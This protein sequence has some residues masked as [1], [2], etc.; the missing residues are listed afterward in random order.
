MRS[1]VA[2][3]IACLSLALAACGPEGDTVS[4]TPRAS[5]SAS[6]QPVGTD[7]PVTEGPPGCL[8]A[9]FAWDP[10]SE[11][12]LL[13]NCVA[14]DNQDGVEQ[15]W[16]WDGRAWTLVADNGPPAMLVTAVGFDTDRSVMVRYGGQP[17]SGPDCLPE[18][19]EWSDG[20]PW[21]QVT[22]TPPT[23]CDHA[24]MVYDAARRVMTMFGGG[25]AEQHLIPET[26]TWDGESWAQ[27][28]ASGDGPSGRA[29][30][31]FVYDAAHEQALLF[32]G[33]DGDQVFGDF[34]AWDG[35]SWTE[36]D[37]PGPTAR[38][39]F[40]MAISPDGL[41]LFGGST[42]SRTM[43]TL[44]DE[45]WFLTNG[46]WSELDVDGPSARDMAALGYDPGRDVFVLFGGF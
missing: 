13:L 5:S 4:A 46:Q 17:L 25:D 34:W 36:L 44:N 22:A 16:S 30:F 27:V 11:R 28:A 35:A 21:Q 1:V 9:Q 23:A 43:E 24:F 14:Q 31:G 32:G 2:V 7:A 41:L 42:G 12:L 10:A 15:V 39:H 19:W 6:E 26:W 8:E 18:T 20:A 33:Y 37:F 3:L 29:H 40:S 38:S 45:T